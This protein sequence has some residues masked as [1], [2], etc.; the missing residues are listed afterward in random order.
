L[1]GHCILLHGH[2]GGAKESFNH[3]FDLENETRRK[4]N[5]AAYLG[6]SID[7]A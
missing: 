1:S 2:G 3:E 6:D 4:I 5:Q 7:F